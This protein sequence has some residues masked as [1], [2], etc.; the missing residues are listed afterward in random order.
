MFQLVLTVALM[1][2]V[3]RRARREFNKTVE[4]LEVIPSDKAEDEKGS[5]D[6]LLENGGAYQNGTVTRYLSK[7]DLVNENIID[8]DKSES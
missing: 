7:A 3:I 2:Y 8:K 1:S 5:T 4:E 6:A